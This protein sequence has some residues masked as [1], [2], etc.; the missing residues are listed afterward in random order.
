[1]ICDRNDPDPAPDDVRSFTTDTLMHST[2]SRAMVARAVLKV[3]AQ[4]VGE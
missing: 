3:G 1:M 2:E 4:L